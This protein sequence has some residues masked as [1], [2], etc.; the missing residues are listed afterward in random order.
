MVCAAADYMPNEDNVSH[1]QVNWSDVQVYQ[2]GQ[3]VNWDSSTL[4]MK[5]TDPSGRYSIQQDL[6]LEATLSK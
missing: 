4:Y 3:W 6:P 5:S 2:N 1:A